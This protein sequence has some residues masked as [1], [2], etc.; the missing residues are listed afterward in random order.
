MIKGKFLTQKK[1][2][3]LLDECTVNVTKWLLWAEI[4]VDAK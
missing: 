4:S 3:L 1:L 2:D